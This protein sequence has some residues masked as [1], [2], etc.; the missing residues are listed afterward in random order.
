MSRLTFSSFT[1]FHDPFSVKVINKI[2]FSVSVSLHSVILMLKR[3]RI[4]FKRLVEMEIYLGILV[5]FS[6]IERF[7]GGT[8][9]VTGAFVPQFPKV[10]KVVK[11][12]WHK[13]NWVHLSTE[14][15]R[16]NPPPH[17]FRILQSWRHQHWKDS[18][19]NL[20]NLLKDCYF[21]KYQEI[22]ITLR[23]L[24]ITSNDISW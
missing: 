14:G 16:Q 4:D 10:G 13:I 19:S 18:L 22:S 11:E 12:R 5:Y 8:M 17:F 3:F 15:V 23:Y 1:V 2:V 6:I 7:S 24:A 20:S 21:D 9:E